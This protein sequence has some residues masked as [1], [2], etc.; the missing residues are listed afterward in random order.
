MDIDRLWDMVQRMTSPYAGGL[1]CYAASAIDLALW[2]LKGKA[3]AQPVYRGQQ[4][5]LA[6]SDPSLNNDAVALQD[7]AGNDA[8]NFYVSSDRVAN[9]NAPA[10]PGTPDL[11]A[12]DDSGRSGS[13]NNTNTNSMRVSIALPEGISA[14][15]TLQIAVNDAA[16]TP[17]ATVTLSAMQVASGLAIVT[18]PAVTHPDV[19]TL[20]GYSFGIKARVEAPAGSVTGNTATLTSSWSGVLSMVLDTMAPALPTWGSVDSKGTTDI[21][22]FVSFY[23]KTLELARGCAF[24]RIA[25]F[26]RE[27][28][29]EP[30]RHFAFARGQSWSRELL[31][32][33]ADRKGLGEDFEFSRGR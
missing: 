14:G 15:D 5:T 31:P 26:E 27:P 7:D 8:A 16:S 10:T 18:L 32:E 28:V 23:S 12:G 30:T 24:S 11:L 25:S 17:L 4:I 21:N 9:L 6:Y 22:G 33:C 13:D 19:N 20:A 2:D 3:L 1:S 29:G